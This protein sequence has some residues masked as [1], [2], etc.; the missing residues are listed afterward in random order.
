MGYSLW[1]RK[2]LDTT[3]ALSTAKDLLKVYLEL[4]FHWVNKAVFENVN[5]YLGLTLKW[6]SSICILNKHTTCALTADK[7][8]DTKTVRLILIWLLAVEAN[9]VQGWVM[10]CSLSDNQI[11]AHS[12]A[13]RET[14]WSWPLAEICLVD[15]C[16]WGSRH[17][18]M[19]DFTP[20]SLKTH[21]NV[22]VTYFSLAKGP[23]MVVFHPVRELYLAG[24]I[25]VSPGR[26]IFL[27]QY[28]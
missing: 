11:N 16:R 13:D 28:N 18:L 5:E 2:E 3:E 17:Q 10:Y 26:L 1:A 4:S 15:S 8:A 24:R 27:L 25:T 20:V 19:T 6:D 22:G 7:L 14:Y 9:R 12:Y 23:G 21:W